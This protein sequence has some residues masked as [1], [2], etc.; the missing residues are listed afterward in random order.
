[1]LA[2]RV[3]RLQTEIQNLQNKL[4]G[5]IMMHDDREIIA[6]D[7]N[8][9]QYQHLHGGGGRDDDDIFFWKQKYHDLE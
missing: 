8:L 2:C 5:K 1:M 7:N 6:T 3:S 4:V 9:H